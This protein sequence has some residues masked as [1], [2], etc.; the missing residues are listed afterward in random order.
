[1]SS[2]VLAVNAELP[3]YKATPAEI[4]RMPKPAKNTVNAKLLAKI[5]EQDAKIKEQDAEI[6]KLKKQ[7]K[8]YAA[9][10]SKRKFLDQFKPVSDEPGVS[11]RFSDE[12]E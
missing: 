5:K 12:D 6:Q 10:D 9:Q 4:V 7:L 2:A 1:V 3:V 8:V 11:L